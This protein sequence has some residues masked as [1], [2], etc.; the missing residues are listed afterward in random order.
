VEGAHTMQIQSAVS[1]HHKG[2][3]LENHPAQ[4]LSTIAHTVPTPTGELVQSK[5][6]AFH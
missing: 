6:S 1:L 5:R 4:K 2:V 3:L